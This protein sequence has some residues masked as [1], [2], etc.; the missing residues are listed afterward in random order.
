MFKVAAR[1]GIGMLSGTGA[2]L[3]CPDPAI[4]SKPMSF[5]WPLP[6]CRTSSNSPLLTDFFLSASVSEHG[7][8]LCQEPM[9]ES[10]NL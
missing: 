5:I 4:L 1:P 2:R 3:E 9:P 10:C 8:K 6:T 7:C